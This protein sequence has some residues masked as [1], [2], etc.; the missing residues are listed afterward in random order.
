MFGW[1]IGDA[2]MPMFGGLVFG[3]A[4]LRTRSI[5]TSWFLHGLADWAL[6]NDTIGTFLLKQAFG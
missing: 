2:V 3:F 6:L 5:V 4:F 1:S